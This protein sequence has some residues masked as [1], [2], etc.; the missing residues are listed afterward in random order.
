M[1]QGYEARGLRD[2]AARGGGSLGLAP[3]GGAAEAVGGV[4]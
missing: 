1:S 3:P 2:G 4:R